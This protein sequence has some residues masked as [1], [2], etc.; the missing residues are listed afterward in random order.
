MIRAAVAGASGYM[1]A[2]LLRLLSVHPKI[3]LTGVT[4][5]RLAGEPLGKA[6]PHLR[7]LS[8]LR[9]HDLDPEWLA[10]VADVVFL[11][12]P[13]MESQKAVPVLR[14]RGCRAIDLSADYRL[15][16]ANDYVTWYKAPHIDLPGLAEAVYGLPELHRKAITGA[17]L[18]AAPGCY[19][20]GAI[21]AT[22]PLLRAGLAR[23]EGIVIDGKSGVTGAGAQG[24]KIEPMYLF[25]EANENVQAYGLAAH[26]H[27]P[28]I[29]QELGA[30][31]GAPLRVAFT[32]H[33]LPL[34]RGLFTTASVPLSTVL[35]TAKLLEVYRE[36]YADE[37]F[38]RVLDE[39]ERPTTRTVV[40]SNFCDVTVVTD[41]RT[42]RAVCVS[43]IDN[44][45]KGGSANGIQ[46]LNVMFGWNERTGL[47]APPVYP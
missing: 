32:P 47:E 29:E 9:F 3:E 31:A 36:F 33:L 39:G 30:L 17:S 7:G 12:L 4:S 19:P 2:E 23:L 1:G 37:P 44:L 16:D 41:P 28:E 5:D 20:A 25:T 13:H 18:V 38:V 40:G 15:R 46:N 8:E 27:T 34:N 21:L 42:N 26:R 10:S 6:Y 43:A 11:A 22:A 24:R 14:R 45:G 35:P